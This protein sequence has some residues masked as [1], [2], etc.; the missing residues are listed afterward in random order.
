MATAANRSDPARSVT[1]LRGVVFDVDGVLTDSAG[2]RAAAW[3]A[4]VDRCLEALP[5]S[6]FAAWQRHPFDE[7]KDYLG[8][9]S[10]KS[11][12]D[13]VL[14][15]LASRG[16]RLP[17]GEPG[18]EPGCGTV[19]AIAAAEERTLFDLLDEHPVNAFADVEPVLGAL[20]AW[21]VKSAAVSASSR[22]N[23]VL[24]TAGIQGLFDTVVDG[25]EAVRLHLAGTPDPAL[26]LEGAKRLHV[27]PAQ[28]AV[29]DAA[30]TGVEGGMRAGFGLVAGINR[31]TS[32]ERAARLYTHGA[33]VVVHDLVGLLR[34]GLGRWEGP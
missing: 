34:A 10:G 28:T 32:H 17:E 22:A 29:A 4:A 1:G 30:P 24:I 26:F 14:A 19:R 3:K 16:L 11:R 9:V 27:P 12:F 2:I 23:D 20:R 18:D 8:L 33:D 7:V 6:R 25:S 15:F 31:E 21:G 13:G 5:E